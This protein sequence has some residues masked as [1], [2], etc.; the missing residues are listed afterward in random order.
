MKNVVPQVLIALIVP[1]SKTTEMNSDKTKRWTA[2][3]YTYK[4]LLLCDHVPYLSNNISIIRV[5]INLLLFR[6]SFVNLGTLL[7]AQ[8]VRAAPPGLCLAE[9]QVRAPAYPQLFI[10]AILPCT[11]WVT[12]LFCL[13]VHRAGELSLW[14]P[15]EL[16]KVWPRFY[17]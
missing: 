11:V 12:L 13:L 5:G 15:E 16:K 10:N 4:I 3:T 7:R 14:R 8:L 1:S 9:A 17:Y 6:L 2:V